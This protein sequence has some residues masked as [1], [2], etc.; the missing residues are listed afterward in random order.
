MAVGKV[1]AMSILRDLPGETPPTGFF[2]PFGFSRNLD[3]KTIKRYR[4]AE[5]KHGR[6]AMVSWKLFTLNSL[7]VILM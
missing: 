2:D 5:L 3:D 4:E 1:L 7:K 6:I